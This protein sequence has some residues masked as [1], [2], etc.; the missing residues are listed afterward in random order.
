MTPRTFLAAVA[1]GTL[2]A[3]AVFVGIV[4]LV[5]NTDPTFSPF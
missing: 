2:T 3:V 1:V 4:M 5:G